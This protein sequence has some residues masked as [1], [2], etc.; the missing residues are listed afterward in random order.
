MECIWDQSN[1][2]RV[3]L[4]IQFD[5]FRS[6]F[7]VIYKPFKST[8]T[9]CSREETWRLPSQYRSIKLPPLD[10]I[11]VRREMHTKLAGS[12]NLEYLIPNLKLALRASVIATSTKTE[13]GTTSTD[14]LVNTSVSL[15]IQR[16]AIAHVSASWK[17]EKGT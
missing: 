2:K 1:A 17:H 9:A 11:R 14:I 12:H 5:S 6:R 8:S 16:A 15:P 7:A 13:V 4:D 3:F 10:H